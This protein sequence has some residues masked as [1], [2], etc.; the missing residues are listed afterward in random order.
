MAFKRAAADLVLTALDG[1]MQYLLLRGLD[2]FAREGGDIDVLVKR[3]RAREALTLVAEAA[4]RGGWAVAG[5]ADIGYLTQICLVQRWGPDGRHKAVKIDLWNGMSWGALGADPLTDAL[6]D[7]LETQGTADTVG[8]VTL[9]QKL[10]YAGYL[11][12][13][14]R[15]RVFS[16][17]APDRI[18]AFA[19][20]HGLPLSEAEIERGRIDRSARW[21]LR[22]AS[23]GVNI[24]GLPAWIVKVVWRAL[25]FT[26][27]PSTFAGEIFRVSG[28]DA[29]RR[30]ALFENFHTI[31]HQSGFPE[32]FIGPVAAGSVGPLSRGTMRLRGQ[33]F[34]GK[35][36][37]VGDASLDVR[38]AP[39][40]KPGLFAK[41]VNIQLSDVPLSSA[42]ECDLE[43]LL[44]SVSNR[45][46]ERLLGTRKT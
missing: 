3:D 35:T 46:L 23:A 26:A 43:A 38:G 24:V 34:R 14:D 42:K 13:G 1:Q 16:V 27:I 31:M 5:L 9:L 25:F 11:R 21:R 33:A 20:A 37:L 15:E 36:V 28:A 40:R 41:W 32:P 7:N 39:A 12:D 10:L 45:A 8:L 2:E 19:D 30:A 44:A 4:G 6:F 17:C 29:P 18:A 22:A